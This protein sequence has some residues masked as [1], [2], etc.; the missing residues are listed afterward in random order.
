MFKTFKRDLVK[1]YRNNIKRGHV[2]VNGNYSTLFGN[3]LEMLQ[4]SCGLF[5]GTS[6]LEI[7]EVYTKNFDYETE[8]VN[9]RSPHVANGN[10]WVS[11][12]CTKEKGILLDKYFNLS[13]Q[14]VIIN[15][16]NNNVLETLS[17]SDCLKGHTI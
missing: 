9:S 8:T 11:K 15:S 1:A 14:I 17:G 6:L 16:M 7:D 2:L 3:A 10:V 12:N 4:S 13:K 5:N